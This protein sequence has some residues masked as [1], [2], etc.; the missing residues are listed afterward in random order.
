[1]VFE[2]WHKLGKIE[3]VR[4]NVR[5]IVGSGTRG[6][7]V[8]ARREGNRAVASRVTGALLR[9]VIVAALVL[10]PS[11]LVPGLSADAQ[12]TVALVALFAGALTYVEYNAE[13]PGLVEFRDAPPFNRTRLALLGLTVFA[14]A[15]IERGRELPS[16]LTDLVTAV[17]TL[18]GQAMDF[19]YSPVRLAT[20]ALAETATAAD[21]AVIR[22]AAGTAYLTTLLALFV[23]S[24]LLRHNWPRPG[25]AFNVWVNLPTFDPTSVSDI[26]ARLE[27]DARINI[28][29][30]FL[31]P[32]L[33]PALVQLTLGGLD[34]AV[35]TAPHTLIWMT[36]AWAFFPASLFMRGIAMLRLAQMIRD[37]RRA[38][39][40]LAEGG[41]QPA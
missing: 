28:S 15:M 13:A 24:F 38:S 4:H 11:M 29:L 32:F 36:A 17:G 19:P 9:A 20:E 18:I 5:E 3:A 8:V 30:G 34:P 41:A 7:P 26:V 31:L 25:R 37:K 23:F 14:L 10:A 6:K 12:Q 39:T 40:A 33:M 22:T 35:V 2:S 21:I 16:T 1:M 27:R